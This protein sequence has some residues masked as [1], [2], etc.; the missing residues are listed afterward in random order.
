MTKFRATPVPNLLRA[1]NE[2]YY[3]R[4][5][6][7]GRQH[8]KSLKTK[9]L[10]VARQRLRVQEED[11]RSRK[12][13]KGLAMSFGQVAE[14]YA[15]Q[16]E[17]EP[18]LAAS[19]KEF[20]LRPAATFRRTWPA[21]WETDIRRI[22]SEQCLE[23]QRRFENGDSKYTPTRA[24]TSVRGNSATVV[25]ACIAYLRR[26]FEIAIKEGL[27]GQNP[28]RSMKRK[29]PGKKLLE[30]PSA[31][32]FRE[33]VAL[34]RKSHAR[35]AE[36]AADFIEGLAYSGM[37]KEEAAALTWS[38]VNKDRGLLTVRGTKTETSNRSVPIIPAMR[39]LLA[40]I[41]NNGP[42]V[43]KAHSALASLA[44]ACEAIGARKL[45]HHD[46]RHLFATTCIE[47]GVDIPTVSRWLG[48][49]DGGALAMKTYGHLRP[50]HSVE[51]AAKVKF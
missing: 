45:T 50:L 21:L 11:V 27:I 3:A 20:R 30:L 2:I 43:F 23:W 10:S 48:H 13:T 34:V 39:D 49:A 12:V 41:E 15:K 36:A 28:A 6:H 44:K 7:L 18:R 42:K 16:V 5:V 51:A 47:S 32:Q 8:W 25:N 1:D 38:D 24:K 4:V 9:V 14:I 31:S 40:R 33:I 35:W 26:V 46:L 19:T 37:R 17:L 22:T 29:R